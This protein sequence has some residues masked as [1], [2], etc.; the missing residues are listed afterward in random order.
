MFFITR[1][2][3]SISTGKRVWYSHSK[4]QESSSLCQLCHLE[5][6]DLLHMITR[7]PIFHSV[8]KE[9]IGQMRK[10]V[11][12]HLGEKFWFS[13][14]KNREDVLRLTMD[15][16]FFITGRNK[17][18]QRVNHTLETISRNMCYRIHHLRLQRLQWMYPDSGLLAK[19]YHRGTT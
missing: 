5:E 13:N 8:R 18:C 7:C 6:E 14:I 17:V 9:H 19:C 16:S 12:E 1:F 10:V 15:S 3:L 4:K 11:N 2:S